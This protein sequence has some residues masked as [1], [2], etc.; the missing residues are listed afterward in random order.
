MALRFLRKALLFKIES[1]YGTDAVP[2]AGT[3]GLLVRNFQVQPLVVNYERREMVHPYYANDGQVVTGFYSQLEFEVELQGAGGAADAVPK[4]GPCMRACSHSQTINAG[5]NVTYAPVSLAQESATAYFQVDGRQHK[6]LGLRGNKFGFRI[7][8]GNIPVLQFGYTGLHVQPTDTATATPDLSGFK[9]PVASNNANTTP[10]SLHAFAGKMREVT[11]D[12]G[13]QSVYRNLINSESVVITGRQPTA[14][15]T[16]E[17]E[18]I[19]TKDWFGIIK[20]MT[21]GA[22]SFTHGTSVG[23]R[24]AFNAPNA[25][26][27]QPSEQPEDNILMLSAG[28]E[29]Q[30]TAGDDEYTIVT[31]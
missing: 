21:T 29:L 26:I 27:T 24:V 13:L 23:F 3:D 16:L 4:W 19:A 15:V 12:M 10:F 9:K 18:L 8:A 20:A 1:T 7:R 22:L 5:S 31:S 2:V 11:F 25:Q 28:L 30:P 6:M 14:N 17:S